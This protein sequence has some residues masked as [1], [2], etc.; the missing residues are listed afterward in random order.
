[1]TLLTFGCP[2]DYFEVIAVGIVLT[3]RA[4]GRAYVNLN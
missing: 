4:K 2:S 3:F 1:L